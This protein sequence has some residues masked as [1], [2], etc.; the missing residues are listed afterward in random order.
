MLNTYHEE[1]ILVESW[2]IWIEPLVHKF[3]FHSSTLLS[4]Y[5]G[6]EI[7]FGTQERRYK[8]LDEPSIITLT[9]VVLENYL[10]LFYLYFSKKSKEEL[11]F[12]NNVWVY[13]GTKQR[14]DFE[15]TTEYANERKQAELSALATYKKEIVE[16]PF[17]KQMGSSMQKGILDGIKPRLGIT[18]KKLIDE[19]Y[20]RNSFFMNLYSFKSSYSHSEYLSV[21]QVKSN[22][23]QYNPNDKTHFELHLLHLLVC[24]TIVDLTEILPAFKSKFE[25]LTFEVLTE[26]EMLAILSSDFKT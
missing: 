22:S 2:Q 4:L 12:R 17:F 5:Q 8:I 21:L 3:G 15:V 16:S 7:V 23:Y 10:T 6:T 1:Q 18:W 25:N 24:R 9:R 20:L 13:S 11:I 14:T 26:I 19:S